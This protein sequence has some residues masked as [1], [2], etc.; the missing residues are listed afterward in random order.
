VAAVRFTY[1]RTAGGCTLRLLE[2]RIL[3]SSR[4]VPVQDWVSSATERELA[5]VSRILRLVDEPQSPVEI[6]GDGVRLDHHT[7]AGFSE[8]QAL[9][10]G[11]PPSIKLPLKIDANGLLTDPEFSIKSTWVGKAGRQQRAVRKGA[12]VVIGD[13][14]YRLP[15]P[16]FGVIEAIDF[17]SESRGNDR[18]KFAALA[19]I[20]SAIPDI[21]KEHLRA[22]G[23]LSSF[24]LQHATAF[25]L[26]LRTVDKSFDFDPI[27]FGRAVADRARDGL[28]VDE[29]ECIL[30]PHQQEVF[31]RGRF[32]TFEDCKDY[33]V[34]ERGVY[35]SIDESLKKSLSI[36]RRMQRADA[37]ARRQFV[38]SPRLFL[39]E[40][41]SELLDSEIESL[42]IETEQYSARVIDIGVWTPPVIPWIKSAPNDW[43]PEKFGLRVENEFV[44]LAPQ[45]LEPLRAKIG[46]AVANGDPFVEFGPRSVRIP[47]TS[48]TIE[49]LQNLVGLSRPDG[50]KPDSKP[51]NRGDLPDRNI[52][53]VLLVE[54]NFETK[55]FERSV[56][57]RLSIN[58]SL[59][60]SV[61]TTLM[62]HQLDGLSWL[63][64][65][66]RMGYSG[67]LLADD[68]G[69]GKT[70]QALAFL[71]WLKEN[72]R[73]RGRRPLLIVAPTGLLANWQKEFQEHLF[74]PGLGNV[75]KAYGSH[76][77]TIKVGKQNDISRGIPSLDQQELLRADC[78][79]TTYETLRDYHLSFAAVPFLCVTFDEMQKV[80]S[81]TSLLTRAA[82]TLNAE[83]IVGLT[84]TPVEN[85]LGDLWCI[86][87]IVRPG[88]LG[89]LKEFASAFPADDHDALDR[90]R[91]ITLESTG[92]QPA[93]VL[94]RL[95][96]DHLKGLPE[97]AVHIRR[98]DM[99]GLQAANYADIVNRA[100]AP[101]AGPMLETLHLLRGISLHPTWPPAS[102][103]ADP[104][105][106]I[107]QSAR[108][109]ETFLI[110]DEIHR[111]R[112]KAL[113]FLE[114]LDLQDQLA[115]LI[116]RRYGLPKRPMQINGEVRGDL[117]Q[118][119][120]DD[121]QTS[122]GSFD[123][124]I[125][126]PRA[127]GVGLTLTSANHVI[128]LS[129]WWNPAVEDQC[130]DRVYRIGAK[131]NVHVYYPLA[132]HPNFGESSFDVL[133]NTLLIRKR[134]LSSRLLMPPVDLTADSQWFAEQ[135]CREGGRLGEVDIREIDSFDPRAFE[136]WAVK[137][138]VGLGWSADRTLKSHDGGAD[139]LFVHRAS[140]S[141]AI[142]QCK[143]KQDIAAKCGSEAIDDLLRARNR[144]QGV[145]RL[146][147]LTNGSGFT[148]NAEE[149]ARKFGVVLIDRNEIVRWPKHLSS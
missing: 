100:K 124:M 52:K 107:V 24:R 39:K 78:I 60:S 31:A 26:S 15:Q 42:F 121:F 44:E 77:K 97:K 146:F 140:G 62:S 53:N 11:L 10:I 111:K 5:V 108:L 117:R 67:A 147:A 61:Q 32:R 12:F 98:R 115:V 103:I 83:F 17:F 13:D 123:V 66:W 22:D 114:S 7:V 29:A 14:T 76:L 145:T 81:P 35:V 135:L 33:Y 45:D 132:V 27:L 137:R 141:R 122:A 93:P 21:A 113:I 106:F 75:L 70:L 2:A 94:R 19:T 102:E 36:V 56:R 9:S 110:L 55:G 23:Y 46:E 58:P 63:Q 69:L 1:E 125:L 40:I 65:S 119:M 87:D 89:S 112:E 85:Q 49:A 128:H 38:R 68:M 47:A 127:G 37:E 74:Q 91:N 86:M 101:E 118:R 43:L 57:P 18:A 148:P 95:K 79:L 129:R 149:R 84:G 134:S 116:Q 90:L 109:K 59:P 80:K 3:R 131:K 92:D 138:C 133:L 144:Y 105:A 25:S 64:Q 96:T 143:H 71:A 16:L 136:S 20:Q 34:I 51:E 73:K 28:P 130:T 120:V 48:A 8:P 99:H 30:T 72:V 41:L 104:E 54:E 50:L 139:G 82:K 4:V 126:S 88:H 142:I 6:S